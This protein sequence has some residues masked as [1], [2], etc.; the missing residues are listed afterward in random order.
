[1]ADLPGFTFFNALSARLEVELSRPPLRVSALENV[2]APPGARITRVALLP[3]VFAHDGGPSRDPTP[4]ELDQVALAAPRVRLRG[5]SGDVVE[6]RAPDGRAFRVR[7]LL[8]AVEETERQT[9]ARS[10]WLGGIDVHHVYFEGLDP[11]EQP[12]VW[13]ITWGS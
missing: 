2:T 9:R 1:M 8:A 5:E 7:D 6:H 13:A 12:G 10:D 3:R 4:G 11:D